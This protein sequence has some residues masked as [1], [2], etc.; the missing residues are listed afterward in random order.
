M[1]PRIWEYGIKNLEITSETHQIVIETTKV[2]MLID[3][4]PKTRSSL[5]NQKEQ[6]EWIQIIDTSLFLRLCA[7]KLCNKNVLKVSSPDVLVMFYQKKKCSYP[8]HVGLF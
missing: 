6:I 4:T 7:R 2:P 3:K 1:A 8:P 5:L